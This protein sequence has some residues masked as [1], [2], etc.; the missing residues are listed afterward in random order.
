MGDGA[1]SSINLGLLCQQ[2]QVTLIAPLRLDARLFGPAPVRHKSTKGRPRQVG[3]RLTKLSELAIDNTQAWQSVELNR[4]GGAKRVVELLTGTALWYS[5]LWGDAPL[6]LR[7]VLVRDPKGKLT[8]KAYFSTNNSVR[9]RLY[10]I[11][12]NIG[13]LK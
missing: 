2:L 6:E 1:Y 7:W 3:Q 9:L 11:S 5:T 12:S 8:P 13:V 10:R 4:Y